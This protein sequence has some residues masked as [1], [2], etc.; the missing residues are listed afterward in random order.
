MIAALTGMRSGEIR[1]FA[2]RHIH[3]D[4]IEINHG[5]DDKLH[6]RTPAPKWGHRRIATVPPVVAETLHRWIAEK[7]SSRR[8]IFISCHHSERSDCRLGDG[9]QISQGTGKNRN[10]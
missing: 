6:E 9:R 2:P 10:R 7:K 8:R 3:E 1:A 5:W 4:Y